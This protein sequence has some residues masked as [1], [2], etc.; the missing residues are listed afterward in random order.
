MGYEYPCH[1]CRITKEVTTVGSKDLCHTCL[2]DYVA[3]LREALRPFAQFP[4]GGRHVD[5]DQPMDVTVTSREIDAAKAA[6][7]AEIAEWENPDSDRRQ[8]LMEET[9]LAVGD[10]QRSEVDLRES[11]LDVAEAA[12]VLA[13]RAR[14][15]AQAERDWTSRE[16]DTLLGLMWWDEAHQRWY[17]NEEVTMEAIPQH[18]ETPL[19]RVIRRLK[20]I[21]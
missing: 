1:H 4:S 9:V 16:Y 12:L 14:D 11:Q 2:S 18:K 20:E 8:A 21:R 15:A 7:E 5:P 6:L 19:N 17:I 13:S 10:G 3:R